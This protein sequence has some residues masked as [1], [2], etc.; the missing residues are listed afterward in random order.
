MALKA[1]N[2]SFFHL[3]YS[4][5]KIFPEVCFKSIEDAEGGPTE[6]SFEFDSTKIKK[7]KYSINLMLQCGMY[8]KENTNGPSEVFNPEISLMNLLA[9]TEELEMF[10]TDTI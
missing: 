1:Y 10:D 5:S 9:D 2:G 3:R 8:I 6:E 4:Y 7:I